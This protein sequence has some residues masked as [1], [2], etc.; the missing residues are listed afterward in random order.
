M[1]AVAS[2]MTV[3]DAYQRCQILQQLIRC[4]TLNHPKIPIGR[5]EPVN[6][7]PANFE[8][9]YW[10]LVKLYQNREFTA[11]HEPLD[12][13]HHSLPHYYNSVVTTPMSLRTILDRLV[14][15]FYASNEQVF[16]D[17]DVI[18]ENAVKFNG[19]TS[20]YGTLARTM[21][22][23]LIDS[24]KRVTPE[25]VA[26]LTDATQ[27]FADDDLTCMAQMIRREAPQFIDEE[28]DAELTM[29]HVGLAEELLA[30]AYSKKG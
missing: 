9:V 12:A 18:V 30:F 16:A 22:S 24:L 7:A 26:Q 8:P 25:F 13:I 10:R 1:S 11:F 27:D 29:L 2:T 19:E 6:P 5:H 28:G 3:N 14:D 20:V 4:A 23:K 15:G 21:K 17:V